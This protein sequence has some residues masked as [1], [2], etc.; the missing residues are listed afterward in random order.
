MKSL[1]LC[2]VFS[3]LLLSAME[4]EEAVEL[5]SQGF[6]FSR[7]EPIK[8]I[9]CFEQADLYF[10]GAPLSKEKASHI[11][12]KAILHSYNG[13][14]DLAEPLY[15]EAL[16]M[17]IQ[18]SD[19]EQA[20]T[21]YSDKILRCTFIQGGDMKQAL[22]NALHLK[23]MTKNS[24]NL[25]L[26]VMANRCLID[27][28]WDNPAFTEEMV[29]IAIENDAWARELQDT[30]ML[31]HSAFDLAYAYGDL[32]KY[33]LALRS[34]RE[35]IV[36]Q[37]IADDHSVS[38]TYN[39]IAN[40]H[41][42]R[43]LY[44]SAL[45]YFSLAESEAILEHRNDG[46]AASN[47]YLGQAYNKTKEY[48][49]ALYHCQKGIKIFRENNILRRQ[50]LCAT[51]ITE[52]YSGLNDK[53]KAYD[54]LVFEIAIKDSIEEASSVGQLKNFH[55][56]FQLKLES[57]SDSIEFAYM[58]QLNQTKIEKQNNRNIFLFIGLGL[59]LIFG[60]FI[61][62]RFR[63]TRKQ[64]SIIE[65]QKVEVARQH[66]ELQETHKEITDSIT[67]AKR[68][69]K[70]I[71]PPHQVV[72]EI[73][74]DAFVLYRPKDVVAGDFY[75]V[76]QTGD[77]ILFAAADCTGHG[78]PGA[79]VSVV[80]NNALKRSVHE[81]KLSKPS[82]ILD[83]TRQLVIEEFQK[84]NEE[85]KDGMDIALCKVN[86]RNLAYSGAHNPLWIIRDSEII[87]F[88]G[89]KQPI[90]NFDAATPFTNHEIQ[91]VSGDIVYV[92]TDGYVD[93][94]GGENG[95][96]LK[97]KNMRRIF[98]EAAKLPIRS[99]REFLKAEMDKWMGDHA[100]LD[101]ICVLG[102]KVENN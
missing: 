52:A 68:I 54:A 10:Y 71:L 50:D 96:K 56:E 73:L 43:E 82:D 18:L 89:D 64:K 72:S 63:I 55:S 16:N 4:K 3:P 78:V 92:F 14:C 65:L 100:Q 12:H 57:T 49:K 67:Y 98:L 75:F 24:D 2:L 11:Y 20:I 48:D 101:D 25:T 58:D 28:Y 61:L 79:M 37:L 42:K 17:A 83:K 60:A 34:Y 87:E 31:K 97:A 59:S 19:F 44:D 91:L 36:Y 102:V 99:Q 84:S 1:L 69:Q 70:A 23:E 95:K 40:I 74:G 39:N 80:C 27:V 22:T 38:A 21:I 77:E 88:K 6:K 53:T 76:E 26:K 93:Q 13:D 45:Y 33:D 81:F 5:S 47:L 15:Q 30:S 94:F 46:I 86:K 29:E 35:V 41:M 32:K 62:N 51:C 66:D 8:A 9:K 7:A 90:G 85:V